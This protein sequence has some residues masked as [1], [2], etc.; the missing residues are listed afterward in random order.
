[1]RIQTPYTPDPLEDDTAEADRRAVLELLPRAA[2][3][4][5]APAP[6]TVSTLSPAKTLPRPEKTPPPGFP[7]LLD[8]RP[9]EAPR[10]L[11]MPPAGPAPAGG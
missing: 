11:A 9:H 5:P 2:G 3:G 4:T 6:A 7:V 10:P 1:V 8:K